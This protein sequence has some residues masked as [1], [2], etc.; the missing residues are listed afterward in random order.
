MYI[1]GVCIK[2]IGKKLEI[3]EKT[4]K[5]ILDKNNIKQRS[6]AEQKLIDN[7]F[8]INFFKKIDTEEKAYILGL[9]YSDG[10]VSKGESGFELN[11]RDIDLLVKIKNYI[12]RDFNLKPKKRQYKGN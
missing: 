9:F 2:H 11:I 4:I 7:H 10:Y 6:R 5:K 1:S 8:D 3:S 12:G